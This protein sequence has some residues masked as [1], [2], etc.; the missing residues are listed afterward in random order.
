MLLLKFRQNRIFLQLIDCLVVCLAFILAYTLRSSFFQ[1]LN[2]SFFESSIGELSDYSIYLIPLFIFT[3]LILTHFSFYSLGF[4]PSKSQVLNLCFQSSILLFLIQVLLMFFFKDSLSRT[5]FVLFIPICATLLFLRQ[6]AILAV[7]TKLTKSSI[8]LRNLLL[9]TDRED[10]T[11]WAKELK[12]H[13]ELGFKIAKQINPNHH[14][15]TDFI[16]LLHHDSIQLV[17]FDIKKTSLDTVSNQLLACEEEGIEVWL[18]TSLFQT[19]I[20]SAKVDYFASRPI[21]IFRSTPDSSW[22]LLGKVIID[23][24]GAFSLL[25]IFSLPMLI[26]SILIRLSSKGPALFSQERSGHY[27]KPF[28]MLKFRSMTSD[29]EQRRDELQRLNEMTGPVFKMAQ[30]PRITPIGNWLRKTSLDELPQLINVLVGDMSLVGP[31]PLPIY[32]T[33]AISKNK[34]RRRLSVKP[35]ITCLWQISGRNN[36]TNFEEWVRLD[37]EYIDKWSLWC[38]III[39]LKTI[40]A[41]L[42]R[43]GAT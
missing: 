35:G 7:R 19:E 1:Y 28:R 40:P 9:V 36:V 16:N 15:L 34:Q 6:L 26:I 20:T 23:R 8:N 42:L 27:G 21:L 43:R 31:R 3:P 10:N 11:Y 29:A 30:D 18:S 4:N 14:D 32:E 25:L 33:L 37:L 5:T 13:P 38:D 24:I 41:V 2:L 17:I 22:Q 39:L 12:Q